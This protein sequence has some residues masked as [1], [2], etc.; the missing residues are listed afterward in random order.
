MDVAFFFGTSQS[1]GPLEQ[2][3]NRVDFNLV[4]EWVAQEAGVVAVAIVCP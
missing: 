2:T 3:V 4:P 1:D